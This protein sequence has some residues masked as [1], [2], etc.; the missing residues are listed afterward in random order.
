MVFKVSD[1]SNSSQAQYF[2]RLHLGPSRGRAE[3]RRLLG[4]FQRIVL[5]D[6]MKNNGFPWKRCEHFLISIE[7]LPAGRAQVASD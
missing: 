5:S 6:H 4:L 2:A 1:V 7:A 3:F